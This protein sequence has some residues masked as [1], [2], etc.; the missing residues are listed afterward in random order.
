[1]NFWK[2][3]YYLCQN[4]NKIKISTI[5]F[6]SQT[7]KDSDL[8]LRQFRHTRLSHN[9]NKKLFITLYN[10]YLL[11][12]SITIIVMGQQKWSLL[13]IGPFERYCIL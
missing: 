9:T 11:N 12:K 1:M 8:K 13:Y 10:H 2:N 4:F 7:L 5:R 6:E 3:I